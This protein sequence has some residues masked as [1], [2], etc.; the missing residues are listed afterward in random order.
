MKPVSTEWIV[1]QYQ[2][3]R[4]SNEIAKDCGMSP[5]GV[6]VRLRGAGVTIRGKH[7]GRWNPKACKACGK[8]FTPSGPAALFC[9]PACRLGTADCE[10][11][12]K[13]FVRR[14]E[15]RAKSAK[16]NRFCSYECRWAAA[17]QRDD[18]GRY[19]DDQGYVV[20]DRKRREATMHRDQPDG[21]VRVNLG[22][23]QRV[24]EHRWVMEQA[25]GRPLEPHETVHHINGDKADNRLENLQL[26]QGR[27]GKG[28]RFTC[29]DCG[30][31]NV[32]ARPI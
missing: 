27:H 23:G 29:V 18:Y 15:A 11:C 19:L 9:S 28:A 24:R 16:D 26:R 21:Y 2:S 32:E 31:H 20:I 25:L 7:Y 13:T 14:I 3:G 5:A 1:E 17:R 4:S 8:E 12:G 30:S 6:I 22:G 10:T